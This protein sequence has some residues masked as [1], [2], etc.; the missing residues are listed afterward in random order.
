MLK[1]AF[2]RLP[3]GIQRSTRAM[4]QEL[5]I[6]NLHRRGLRVAR[7]YR[8]AAGLKLHIGCGPNRK[9]GWVNIDL[10]DADLSLDLRENLPFDDASCTFIYSEH[11]MEHLDYP[12]DA[13]HFLSESYRV[14]APGG[15]FSV[16]VPDTEMILL[17]YAGAK[18][19]DFFDTL[20]ATGMHPNSC[21]TRAEHLDFHFRQG[22]EHKF[23]YDFETMKECL[24]RAGFSDVRRRAFDP[25]LDYK[26][27]D[28]FFKFRS[29]G[30]LYVDGFKPSATQS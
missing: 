10:Q 13:M 27:V 26:A 5:R 7:R 16:G 18:H 29:E 15:R 9:E 11:F 14:L 1:S 21:Q 24:E 28:Q 17:A 3:L 4:R 6:A 23:A 22:G 8:G 19:V 30:T 12:T 25:L 20:K 2:R